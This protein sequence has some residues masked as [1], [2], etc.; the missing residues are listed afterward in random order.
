MAA[1]Q[2]QAMD[3]RPL[4]VLIHVL[5]AFL[6][7][8]GYVG[9]NLCT[10]LARRATTDDECRTALGLSNRFDRWLNA[11]GGTVTS[12]SGLVAVWV[13]G[14][15]ITTPWVALAIALFAGIVLLG[16]TFWRR[17]GRRVD[18]A[19]AAGDWTG[20]RELL[21]EPRIVV[22]SRLENAVVLAIIVLMVLRPG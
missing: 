4:A 11:P 21:T 18:S 10:E 3:W 14:Y 17:F 2:E 8:A 22:V 16:I 13:F 6:Y 15:A 12:L 9:T 19:M 20:V 1:S 5:A 7:F